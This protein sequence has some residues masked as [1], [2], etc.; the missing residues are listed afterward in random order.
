MH[1]NSKG[2][3]IRLWDYSFK[4]NKLLWLCV[5]CVLLCK[6]SFASINVFACEPEY[7]ELVKIIDPKANIY[8]ATTA[9]QDPHLIQ[10]RP[11][12]IAQMRRADLLVCA[13]A[14]LEVGWLPML[15]MKSANP[16]IQN[17]KIGFF[18]A[19][20]NVETLDKLDEVSRDMGDVHALGNP[21]V[22]FDPHL[23]ETIAQKL[24]QRLSQLTPANKEYYEQ[25]L[26]HFVQTW[27][28]F[29]NQLQIEA[30]PLRGKKVIAYHSNFRYLFHWLDIDQVADLEPKPGLPPSSHHLANLLSLVKQQKIDAI[31]IASYQDRRGANWLSEKTGLPIIVLP[32]TVGG[33]NSSSTL[34]KLYENV[35]KLLLDAVS[36]QQ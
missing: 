16:N 34:F 19:A 31:V 33:N 9:F 22:H 5:Y 35:V 2:M 32:L 26:Q 27:T 3:T 23:L 18:V 29:I 30:H 17:G 1:I 25:N 4:N 21:H 8:I 28:S 36:N 11:S 12:L 24:Q 6:P 15:Q 13:G 7:G 20:Q 14:D 10:A